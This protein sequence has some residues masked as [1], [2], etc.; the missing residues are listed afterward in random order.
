M[1]VYECFMRVYVKRMCPYVCP[2]VC[3]Y[4]CKKIYAIQPLMGCDVKISINDL[5]IYLS[6]YLFVLDKSRP[7]KLHSR[8][9]PLKSSKIPKFG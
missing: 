8:K 7:K 3:V 2:Y 5:S 1:Y 9:E 6:F 4:L